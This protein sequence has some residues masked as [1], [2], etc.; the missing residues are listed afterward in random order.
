MYRIVIQKSAEKF[1]RKQSKDIQQR[2]YNGIKLLPNGAD[3][4]KLKGFSNKYRSRIGKYRIVF[5]KY[6]DVYIIDVVEIDSRG[7]IYK[8]M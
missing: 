5:D 3:I 2:L 4:I 8:H 1:I 7:Q 6:D